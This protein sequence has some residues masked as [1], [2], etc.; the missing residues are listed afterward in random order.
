MAE[1]PF[2]GGCLCGAVR[3]RIDAPPLWIGYCHC[4]T[5]RHSTGA[6][7]TMFVGAAAGS[8]KFANDKRTVF[9]SSPGVERG[10]C[11]TCGTPLTYESERFPGEVHFHISTF[12]DPQALQPAFHVFHE[13]RLNW[14]EIDDD[15]PRHAKSTGTEC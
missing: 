5:C 13:E 4:K 12:D 6:P 9:V 2:E 10:F 11:P 8:V 3:Y 15:L 1:P 14:L 7:V